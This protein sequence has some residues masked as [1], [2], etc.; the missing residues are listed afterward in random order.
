M[1]QKRLRFYL[2]GRSESINNKILELNHLIR[3]KPTSQIESKRLKVKIKMLRKPKLPISFSDVIDSNNKNLI[4]VFVKW[5][6]KTRFWSK[7]TILSYHPTRSRFIFKYLEH[8][9]MDIFGD[10]LIINHAPIRWFSLIYL[11]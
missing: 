5:R 6:V 9:M 10:G 3:R 7:E 1:I 2:E 4:K 11:F 8:I